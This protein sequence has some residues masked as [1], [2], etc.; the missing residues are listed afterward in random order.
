MQN[1]A[2]SFELKGL[3][4]SPFFLWPGLSSFVQIGF[5]LS[6]AV[7]FSLKIYLCICKAELDKKRQRSSVCCVTLQITKGGDRC[8]PGAWCF[9]QVPDMSG[10]YLRTWPI[11]CFLPW[12]VSRKLNQ[13]CN[14]DPTV[15]TKPIYRALIGCLA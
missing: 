10:R 1:K 7:A 11:F 14:T 13:K 15:F 6:I 2:T 5:S 12:C 9:F 4:S 8:K 3:Q